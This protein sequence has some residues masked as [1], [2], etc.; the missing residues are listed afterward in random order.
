MPETP[1]VIPAPLAR[2][3]R[4]AARRE[5]RPV[6]DLVARALRA[7]ID[8]EEEASFLRTFRSAARRKGIRSQRAI[9]RLVDDA[10]RKD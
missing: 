8:R 2:K 5:A 7:Y 10:R 9:A 3:V 4:G 6:A 1:L